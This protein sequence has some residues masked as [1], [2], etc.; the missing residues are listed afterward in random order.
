MSLSGLMNQTIT[1]KSKT[2][3]DAYGRPVVV[4]GTAIKA[5]VELK[6]KRRMMPNGSMVVT[7][8]KAFL[9]ASSTL[10]QD[11]HFVYNGVEYRVFLA[12]QVPGGN[13]QTHHIQIEFIKAKAS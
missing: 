3:Y 13:G 10:T 11:D 7:D 4:S 9:P 2:S 6:Q 8:G 1:P 12:Y 5:R